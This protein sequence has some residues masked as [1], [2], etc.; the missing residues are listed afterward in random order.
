[1][2][3]VLIIEDEYFIAEFMAWMA[4]INGAETTSIVA[5][6]GSAITSA[7]NRM[8]DLI[9]SDVNLASGGRGPRAVERIRAELGEVP[10][11][12]VT[13]S[14]E[15]CS[16]CDYASAILDKP[17]QPERLAAAMAAIHT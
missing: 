11:I 12:F 14:P 7:T 4:E 2:R 17:V 9:L 1:M 3:H 8:P 15:D 5:S 13:A 16:M 6:E 10:V